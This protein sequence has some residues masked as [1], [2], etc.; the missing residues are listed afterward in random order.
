M[1]VSAVVIVAAGSLALERSLRRTGVLDGFGTQRAERRRG[2]Q[3][4][5]RRFD[6]GRRRGLHLRREP[7]TGVSGPRAASR[8]GPVAARRRA[9]RLGEEHGRARR[10]PG[11]SRAS[12][13]G[14]GRA[15]CCIGDVEV[16][17]G[18]VDGIAPITVTTAGLG[19]GIVLQ[20][21]ASQLVME[22]VGD[23][24][25]FGLENAAWPTGGDARA[26][27]GG[28]RGSGSRRLRGPPVDPPVR[29]RAAAGRDRRS[30]R[31]GAGPARPRRADGESRPG[32]RGH[33]RSRILAELR[34]R[35][36]ATIV[37]VEHRAE[38][39]WPI[40][41]L[42][43]ALDDDG[44]PID[45][46]PPADVLSAIGRQAR[47]RRRV[48]ARATGA[49][50]RR[51]RAAGAP[52]SAVP[53]A[54][55]V[56]REP[57]PRSSSWRTSGSASSPASRC[58]AGRPGRRGRASA[59]RSSGRTGAARRRSCGSRWACS[60]R[61]P[62]RCGSAAATRGGCPPRP[63]SRLA[64]YVVQDPELGFLADSVREEVEL[65]L[66]AGQVRVCARAV[67]PASIAAGG[68]RR[69]EPVPPLRRRTAPALARDRAR[70]PAAPARARRADVR[71]GPARPRGARRGARRAGGAGERDA[72]GNPRRAVRARRD[73]PADRAR[74]RLGRRRRARSPAATGARA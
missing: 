8:A 65:G 28:A 64:G 18:E 53:P 14:S 69:P 56:T 32:G 3:R 62:G 33:G 48:A 22:R 20:D 23:D 26:R 63:V 31:D 35:R 15:R 4:R 61:R 73:R 19:A 17:R 16:A 41:D 11:C 44:R 47:A 72:R 43:L 42:V 58:C 25:A 27:A 40:A 68:V 39:A 37:L 66:E 71:P 50:T 12:F 52:P 54:A 57:R 5:P 49:R 59:S 7:A 55:P 74:R 60:A 9:V 30:A 67:R 36:A 29:R 38:L 70:A 21:P 46:G 45:V 6:P 51:R 24:V 1:A 34:A 10:S 2:P 13:R